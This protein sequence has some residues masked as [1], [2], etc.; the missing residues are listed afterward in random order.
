[1]RERLERRRVYLESTASSEQAGVV[2]GSSTI[3]HL[4]SE[5]ARGLKALN[6]P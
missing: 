5:V 2:A 1:V 6:S 4:E 3:E